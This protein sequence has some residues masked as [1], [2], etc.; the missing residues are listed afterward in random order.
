MP[1]VSGGEL[2]A[3]AARLYPGIPVLFISG[4]A[5]NEM[6]KRRLIPEGAVFLQKPFTPGDLIRATTELLAPRRTSPEG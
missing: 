1:H 3:A 6:I 4:Y 2:S 5:G